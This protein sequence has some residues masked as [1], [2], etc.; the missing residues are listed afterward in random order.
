MW[1]RILRISGKT[2]VRSEDVLKSVTGERTKFNYKITKRIGHIVRNNRYMVTL[3]EENNGERA[4]ERL[5]NNSQ[6]T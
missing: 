3:I 6:N 1:R 2:E 4:E 5:K